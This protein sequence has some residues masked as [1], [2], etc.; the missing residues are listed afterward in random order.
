MRPSSAPRDTK[1]LL[2]RV[3]YL[4]L[5]SA[6]C[7]RRFDGGDA[8]FY[9]G[10]STA[11]DGVSDLGYRSSTAPR[12]GALRHWVGSLG[13]GLLALPPRILRACDSH[14][15]EFGRNQNGGAPPRP[16]GRG[17]RAREAR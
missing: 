8:H 5:P 2:H 10:G 7:H 15:A 12:G 4:G 16:E 13:D 14:R 3:P 11:R 6:G 1:F 9:A 17:F